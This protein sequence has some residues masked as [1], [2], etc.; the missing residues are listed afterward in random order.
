MAF[1]FLSVR[2]KGCAGLWMLFAIPQLLYQFGA[3]VLF[4]SGYLPCILSNYILFPKGVRVKAVFNAVYR[5]QL[6]RRF[7][8]SFG[9]YKICCV[10]A[11]N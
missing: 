5:K 8:V 10:V 11:V 1:F 6:Y 9:R 3:W 4:V 7:D 2:H